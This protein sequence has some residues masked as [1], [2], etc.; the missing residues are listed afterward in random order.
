MHEDLN[1]I[2]T[3]PNK[4]APDVYGKP[5]EDGARISWLH[6]FS[7]NQSIITDTMTGMF[8]STLYC[9]ECR[10]ESLTFDTFTEVSLPIP[11]FI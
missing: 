5:V 1:R 7:R 6:Y 11:N 8:K 9:Y 3:K 2:K 4:N 10:R